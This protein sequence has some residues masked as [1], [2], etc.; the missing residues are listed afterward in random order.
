M[1]DEQLFYC[2][3]LVI[4]VQQTHTRL[5]ISPLTCNRLPLEVDILLTGK[6]GGTCLHI[7][8]TQHVYF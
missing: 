1:K 5:M 4:R 8:I 6:Q 2:G 3:R 7:A